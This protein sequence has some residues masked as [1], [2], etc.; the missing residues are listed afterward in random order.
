M[1]NLLQPDKERRLRHDIRGCIHGMLL[2]LAAMET[3]MTKEEKLEFLGDFIGSADKM[4]ELMDELEAMP[5]V[6][7]GVK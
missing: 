7:E 5:V 6:G 1:S 4:G 3:P 2:L